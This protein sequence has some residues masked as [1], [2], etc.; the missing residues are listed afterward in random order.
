MT[1]PDHH[2]SQVSLAN[3]AE[4]I[5]PLPLVAPPVL[6]DWSEADPADVWW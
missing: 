6:G 2:V 1:H 3:T 5:G 4:L